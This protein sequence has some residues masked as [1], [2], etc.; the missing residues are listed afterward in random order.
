L[1]LADRGVRSSVV[2]LAPTVHGA[3]DGGFVAT[4]AQ[5]ARDR[6]F[7]GYVDDGANRWAAVHRTD[8]AALFRLAIEQARGGSILHGAAEQGISIRE[9][10]EVLGAR[11]EL[12]VRSVPPQDAA[13]HFGW[14]ATFIAL[15]A[16]ATSTVTRESLGW[17][18][19]GPTLL[20]DVDAGHYDR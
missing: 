13:E 7:V 5:I 3:G 2:R 18:P 4:Y 1:A 12:P 17:V 16:A 10:A 14:F 11:M 9:L 19:S 15:D 6:G 20:Q 8:A